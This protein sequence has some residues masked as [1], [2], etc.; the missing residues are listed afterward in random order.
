[1]EYYISEEYWDK[2]IITE[3]TKQICECVFSNK[4]IIHIYVEPFAYNIASCQVL[5]KAGFQY[6]STWWN[7]TV[8]N[9]KVIDMKIEIDF[10]VWCLVIVQN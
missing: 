1:M 5:E 9:G 3:A 8:K 4:D 2:G 6:K 7:N 10:S